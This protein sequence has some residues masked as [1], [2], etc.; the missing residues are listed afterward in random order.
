MEFNNAQKIFEVDG[1]EKPTG[2]CNNSSKKCWKAAGETN[3][4]VNDVQSSRITSDAVK[5]RKD[6]ESS[7]LN[8][9]SQSSVISNRSCKNPYLQITKIIEAFREFLFL[10][11]FLKMERRKDISQNESSRSDFLVAKRRLESVV[12]FH[13]GNLQRLTSNV[14]SHRQGNNSHRKKKS[15]TLSKLETQDKCVGERGIFKDLTES[16]NN[17]SK[18]VSVGIYERASVQSEHD[19]KTSYQRSTVE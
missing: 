8:L 13:G 7:I 5:K 9:S 14:S 18:G 4:S 11:P 1:K 17:G 15:S 10:L 12:L 2:S 6:N 3:Q 19:D 16:N